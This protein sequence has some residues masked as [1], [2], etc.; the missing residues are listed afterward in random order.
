MAPPPIGH[1]AQT[2][3]PPNPPLL[4]GATTSGCLRMSLAQEPT[5]PLILLSLVRAPAQKTSSTSKAHEPAHL[6]SS[7]D[8]REKSGSLAPVPVGH[9]ALTPMCAMTCCFYLHRPPPPLP[10]GQGGH[11]PTHTVPMVGEC[12][13]LAACRAMERGLQRLAYTMS[14]VLGFADANP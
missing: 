1:G 13:A 4:A 10:A 11:S 7:F 5:H 8:F 12:V 3:T 2:P 9:G 6:P 14:G